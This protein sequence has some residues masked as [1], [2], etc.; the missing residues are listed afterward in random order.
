MLVAKPVETHHHRARIPIITIGI[1]LAVR[2][3]ALENTALAGIT[4]LVRAGIEIVAQYGLR[5]TR[6][7]AGQVGVDA[8]ICGHAL[9]LA[10]RQV[11]RCP[12][13]WIAG[14]QCGGIVIGLK[15]SHTSA[16]CRR[17]FMQTG[18]NRIRTQVGGQWIQI[19]AKGYWIPRA[20]SSTTHRPLAKRPFAIRV[21]GASMLTRFTVIAVGIFKKRTEPI[22]AGSGHTHVPTGLNT[23]CVLLA[24]P[25]HLQGSCAA[26]RGLTSVTH[27]R[28]AVLIRRFALKEFTRMIGT[29]VRIHRA[30][31]NPVAKP[32]LT[33]VRADSAAIQGRG[34]LVVTISRHAAAKPVLTLS[35]ITK[36]LGTCFGPIARQTLVF[37][38]TL[39]TTLTFHTPLGDTRCIAPL[40]LAV[41]IGGASLAAIDVWMMDT[42][43]QG[44][45][46]RIVRARISIVTRHKAGL[47]CPGCRRS[48]AASEQHQSTTNQNAH[49]VETVPEPTVA[50]Q[51]A[52]LPI[53]VIAHRSRC[54]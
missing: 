26:R 33:L 52:S 28:C 19:G 35:R 49:T 24:G 51:F 1:R 21:V 37:R 13:E 54:R 7:V 40:K 30:R 32:M 27:A 2:L 23:L 4:S 36:R 25:N 20:H 18:L 17:V 22:L 9:T 42:H 31:T 43:T 47:V 5:Q 16:R 15:G 12:R 10:H 34:V 29:A 11:D 45:V 53:G 41:Q 44:W 48:I 3:A 38:E 8:P 6:A 50:R 14:I 46:A 39:I